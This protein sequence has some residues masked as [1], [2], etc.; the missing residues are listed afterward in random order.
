[1]WN[2]S[3][4][5]ELAVTVPTPAYPTDSDYIPLSAINGAQTATTAQVWTTGTFTDTGAGL[6]VLAAATD[7]YTVKAKYLAGEARSVTATATAPVIAVP[8]SLADAYA[9]FEGV[10]IGDT[11]NIDGIN[12]TKSIV[13]AKAHLDIPH[14]FVLVDASA[15]TLDEEYVTITSVG[16]SAATVAGQ[17]KCNVKVYDMNGNEMADAS[18][19][20]T[21]CVVKHLNSEGAV[22]NSATVVL[23]GD[24]NGDGAYATV[25]LIIAEN[26]LL[27][28]SSLSGAFDIASDLNGDKLLSA[29]DIIMMEN[30]I[31]Y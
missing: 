16:T 27:G 28:T 2:N 20:G 23:A 1:M 25:D 14:T 19:S 10:Q 22:I 26:V 7:G 18:V 31:L 30:N 3:T 5:I 29:S 17:F 8:A 13:L 24:L 12:L 21:G 15:Y 9:A 6:L 4:C 11:V